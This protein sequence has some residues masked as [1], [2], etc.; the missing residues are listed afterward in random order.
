MIIQKQKPFEEILEALKEDEKIFIAG[1]SECATTCK[2]GGEEEVAAMKAR[3]EEHG[4][5]VTGTAIF[6]TACLQGEVRK[7]GEANADA[8]AGAD[9]ILV[10]ACGGGVQTIGDTLQKRVHTGTDSLFIGEVIHLGKYQEKCQACGECIL[11]WT[12]GICPVTRCAKG[13]LNGPCGGYT[14]EGKCEVDPDRECAWIQIYN[15]LRER[16]KLEKMRVLRPAKDFQKMSKPRTFK[17]ERERPP[18]GVGK[19]KVATPGGRQ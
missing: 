6:D 4:K 2:V 18:K 11:E 13:L 7:K 1:C 3:L 10:L 17:W 5:A 8:I 19:E 16:G 14:K 12:E 15:R 9:S